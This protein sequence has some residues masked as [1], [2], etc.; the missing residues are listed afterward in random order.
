MSNERVLVSYDGCAVGVYEE[1]CIPQKFLNSPLYVFHTEI[2]NTPMEHNYFKELQI[3]KIA[4][5]RVLCYKYEV[6]N[7]KEDII[8]EYSAIREKLRETVKNNI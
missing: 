1:K 6:E 2:L 8:L 3:P 7:M 5:V 4:S